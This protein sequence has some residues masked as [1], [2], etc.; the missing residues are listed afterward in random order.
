MTRLKEG[1]TAIN[2]ANPAIYCMYRLELTYGAR[3]WR[4]EIGEADSR[5]W[6]PGGGEDQNYIF[7]ITLPEGRLA[8]TQASRG[9]E[10]TRCGTTNR[11][12]AQGHLA[13]RQNRQ[14]PNLNSD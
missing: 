11:T 2:T 4:L 10:S 7:S 1:C 9:R 5:N 12:S 8:R 3:W 6:L 13:A 14:P